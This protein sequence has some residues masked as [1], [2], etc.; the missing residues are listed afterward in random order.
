MGWVPGNKSMV[1]SI[2]RSS[3]NHDEISAKTSG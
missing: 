3:G 1:N 2:S